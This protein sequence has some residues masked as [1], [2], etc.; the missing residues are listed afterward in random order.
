MRTIRKALIIVSFLFLLF[1]GFGLAVAF[2]FKNSAI[3]YLKKYL[4]KHLLTEIQV[5]NIRFSVL[6]RF[7]YAT[8]ELKNVVVK[9]TINFKSSDFTTFNTDTLLAAKNVHF[10]F[11][12]LSMIKGNYKL[13]NIEVSNGKL[14]RLTDHDGRINYNIWRSEKP[15]KEGAITFYLQNVIFS[16][17]RLKEIN[18]A[19]NIR[20]EINI[21]KV[22]LRGDFSGDH[23]SFNAR[24]NGNLNNFNLKDITI[25]PKKSFSF[26]LA[27]NATDGKYRIKKGNVTYSG[28]DFRITGD[29]SPKISNETDL[30]ID[31]TK[32]SLETLLTFLPDKFHPFSSQLNTRGWLTFHTTVKGSFTKNNSPSIMTTL[33]IYKGSLINKKTKSA[34]TSISLNGTYTNG[35]S[36]NLRSSS[37]QIN[38]VNLMIKDQ[39][40]KGQ[41]LI[42]NFT[43][44]L[45]DFSLQGTIPLDEL[46]GFINS[47]SLEFVS[48]NMETN[49]RIN[50]RINSFD[51]I[52]Q[53]DLTNLN[54]KGNILFK[55]ASFKLKNMRF[56]MKNINGEILYDK[57]VELHNFSFLFAGN[58]ILLNGYMKNGLEYI[59]H[60][61]QPL[62]ITADVKSDTINVDKLLLNIEERSGEQKDKG[63]KLPAFL[64]VDAQLSAK[65]FTYG[66]FHA[67]NVNCIVH[68]KPDSLSIQQFDLNS[69]DGSISGQATVI[70]NKFNNFEVTYISNLQHIN[71][72]QLFYTFNNFGQ[73]VILDKNMKGIISGNVN[74]RADW[75]NQLK[76]TEESIKALCDIEI[77]DG[78]LINFEPVLGLSRFI[79]VDELKDIRFK[80]LKNQISIRD[81]TVII[82]QMDIHSSAFDISG[83]GMHHFDDSY[84]YRVRVLLSDL[85]FN[86][87]KKRKKENSEFG[88]VEDDGLGRTSLYLTIKGKG[89]DFKVS[90][91]KKRAFA[92]LAESLRSQKK[93]LNQMFNP[94]NNKNETYQINNSTE[95]KKDNKFILDWED[96]RVKKDTIFE[97]NDKTTKTKKPKFIIKWDDDAATDSIK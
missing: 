14:L 97:K 54:K 33:E 81:K 26:D 52:S 64:K 41:Y 70:Q 21:K 92:S 87:A 68:Y 85:L 62:E 38:N 48:G 15:G 49:L 45:I 63:I 91:D 40:I 9:S 65:N 55:D 23:F 35:K 6:K 32:I 37:L 96:N 72:N 44:P 46:A 78:E 71:I 25:P 94:N 13:K 67:N 12:L 43:H 50:G 80:T 47:D 61:K 77:Q 39:Q 86:K 79:E 69:L 20:A 1:V 66:K 74:L 75:N 31:G 11:G 90:Y 8:V 89:S 5:D 2:F 95:G 57:S 88:L 18:L 51:S 84:E 19:K 56:P 53:Y 29:I 27:V 28:M 7:P 60:K 58:D 76:I 59:F 82:P 24:G 3:D 73:K 42:Q 16:N 30:E 17:I 34:I 10:E 22:N 4:D 93:E 83:S 36:Q